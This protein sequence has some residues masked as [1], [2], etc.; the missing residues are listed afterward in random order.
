MKPAIKN[1]LMMK[2]IFSFCLFFILLGCSQRE[3]EPQTDI[4]PGLTEIGANTAGVI[5]EE[6]VLVPKDGINQSYG[7]PG[8]IK[9]LNVTLGSNFMESKGNDSFSL[10]LKNV[11]TKNGF[12]FFMD[13]GILNR[14]G[15]YFTED[16]PKWPQIYVQKI[17]EGSS[18][19]KYYAKKN[20]CKVTLN[21]LDFESGIIS[22]TFSG[23]L[24][25]DDGNKIT[26]KDGRFDIKIK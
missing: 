9:G 26:L 20:S 13:I 21:K 11:P 2:N 17:V 1:Q 14:T 23:E 8:I 25:D 22:G 10:A 18:V 4:L 6:F 5:I 12:I 3:E 24:Y 7:G 15:D 19:K 16:Y